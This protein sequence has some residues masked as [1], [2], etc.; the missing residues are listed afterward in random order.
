MGFLRESLQLHDVRA[1][2][3]FS[4]CCL[5]TGDRTRKRHI[6]EKKPAKLGQES[7]TY[8]SSITA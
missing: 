6:L 2:R 4:G 5:D 7:L 1:G 8:T 3:D